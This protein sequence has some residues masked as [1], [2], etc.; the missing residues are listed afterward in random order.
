MRENANPWWTSEQPVLLRDVPRLLIADDDNRPSVSSVY[1]WT[2]AG[3]GGVRLR[4][5]RVTPDTWATTREELTRFQAA[6]TELAGE[7]VR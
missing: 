6:Q 4:R 3:C 5:F 2:T 7:V 1:R